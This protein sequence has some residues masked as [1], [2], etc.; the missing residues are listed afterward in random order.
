[1]STKYVCRRCGLSVRLVGEDEG[2]VNSWKHVAGNQKGCGMPPDVVELEVYLEFRRVV[3]D[4][5]R[6]A[7]RRK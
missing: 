5:R 6:A 3:R 1:M 2:N 4:S 7:R